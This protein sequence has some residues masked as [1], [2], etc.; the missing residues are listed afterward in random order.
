MNTY[1]HAM[2]YAQLLC[3][4]DAYALIVYHSSDES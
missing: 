2:I 1:K 3:L 4:F